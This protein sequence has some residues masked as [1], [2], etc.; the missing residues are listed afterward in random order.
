V[1]VAA[2]RLRTTL[3]TRR[4]CR[5]K[6]QV[7]R[8]RSND[9]R[10]GGLEEEEEKVGTRR[11]RRGEFAEEAR[12]LRWVRRE[13]RRPCLAVLH[14][15]R[16]ISCRAGRSRV[17]DRERHE[18]KK[19]GSA[20]W[21]IETRPRWWD[22]EEFRWE[23][24]LS[25]ARAEGPAWHREDGE[26]LYGALALRVAQRLACVAIDLA[27]GSPG[28]YIDNGLHTPERLHIL[29]EVISIRATFTTH[30]SEGPL[31]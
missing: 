26:Q 5:R 16:R 17:Q 31:S 30:V 14:R 3:Q 27:Q 24:P 22:A 23:C 6:P 21:S 25:L 19:P 13:A 15:S 1:Q 12:L 2:R 18:V 9:E 4:D 11:R 7:D 29:L 10:G 28:R 20:L 8:A